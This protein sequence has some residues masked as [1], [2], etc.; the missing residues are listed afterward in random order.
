MPSGVGTQT[1][2]MIEAMLKTGRFSFVCLAG[3]MK[4]SDYRMQLVENPYVPKEDWVIWPV[5]GYG[6]PNKI[7]S[8]IIKHRPDILWFMTDPRFYVWLWEIE[9]EIRP[10]IPMVYYHVWDNYP[11]PKFNK[12]FYISNDVIATISKVTSDIVQRV[13]P[14]VEAVSYT[15]LTLPTKRIV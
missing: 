5:D 6:D 9:H 13:A 15:H 11:L 3:A 8:A 4:H 1:K 12:P 2:Y 7:K 14:E 10:L